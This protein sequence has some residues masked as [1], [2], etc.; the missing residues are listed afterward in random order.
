MPSRSLLTMFTVALLL[1]VTAAACEEDEVMG[2]DAQA[3]AQVSGE[4][5]DEHLARL[6]ERLDLTDEQVTELRAIFE[7]QRAKF[8]ALRESAPED[9]E[10]RREEF[11]ELRAE[12]HERVS[13]VLTEEQQERLGELV[14]SHAGSHGPW[15]VRDPERHLARL[16]ERL[17]LTDAQVAQF[18]AIF[19]EQ[20]A[21]FQALRESAPEDHEALHEAFGEL[22][23]ETHERMSAV[24]TEE[25]RQR[26]EELKRSR[27]HGPR[28]PWH[29]GH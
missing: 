19:E 15:G 28:G 9:R 7:E 14:R 5:A 13:E 21:K 1:A 3:L 6:Q 11:R 23:E 25:Q 4:D 17:D 20:R 29:K 12:T 16:Q 27:A 24:L 26:F 18:R 2:L 10:A 22:H 8:Q